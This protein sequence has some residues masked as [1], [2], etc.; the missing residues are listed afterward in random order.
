MDPLI[1]LDACRSSSIVSANCLADLADDTWSD[2]LDCLK[3]PPKKDSPATNNTIKT[4]TNE[5]DRVFLSAF[6]K[7]IRNADVPPAPAGVAGA[8]KYAAAVAPLTNNKFGTIFA[9]ERSISQQGFSELIGGPAIQRQQQNQQNTQQPQNPYQQIPQQPQPHNPRKNQ[10]GN[11]NQDYS[12]QQKGNVEGNGD[13]PNCYEIPRQ[14]KKWFCIDHPQGKCS[15]AQCKFNHAKK[16]EGGDAI[17]PVL[18]RNLN[19][20]EDEIDKV[21]D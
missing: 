12:Q 4:I 5:A 18:Q 8:D 20:S 15:R 10:K 9:L 11:G 13:N 14:P 2:R 7:S 6:L 3:R 17:S 21:L 16:G 19:L 1:F